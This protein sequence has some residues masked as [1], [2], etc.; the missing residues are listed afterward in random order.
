MLPGGFA[1]RFLAQKKKK[2]ATLQQSFLLV[3]SIPPFNE[4]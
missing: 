2:E 4:D 1:P 3:S